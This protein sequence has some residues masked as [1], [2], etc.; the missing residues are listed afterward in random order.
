MQRSS[1][2]RV[3]ERADRPCG[4]RRGEVRTSAMGMPRFYLPVP[5]VETMRKA[6]DCRCCSD[7]CLFLSETHRQNAPFSP[8]LCRCCWRAMLMAPCRLFYFYGALMSFAM[9][10]L[11]MPPQADAAIRQRR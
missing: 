9:L 11:P 4:G 6:A 7:G 2:G 1:R 3:K 5:R 8:L 10:A